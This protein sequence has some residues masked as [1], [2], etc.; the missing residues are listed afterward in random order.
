M[1]LKRFQRRLRLIAITLFIFNSM[2]FSQII[3]SSSLQ[4]NYLVKTS[5]YPN[6]NQS[7]LYESSAI[8]D[9][10]NMNFSYVPIT[11]EENGSVAVTLVEKKGLLFINGAINIVISRN[12][13]KKKL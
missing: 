2:I 13:V 5:Y 7:M 6:L 12:D 8:M 9:N 3:L 4:E 1:Y 10:N 11:S